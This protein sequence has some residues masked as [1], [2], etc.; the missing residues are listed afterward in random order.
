MLGNS[1]LS[2]DSGF[3]PRLLGFGE[4]APTYANGADSTAANHDEQTG[5]FKRNEHTE[6]ATFQRNSKESIK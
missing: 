4:A 2:A 6:I 5:R 1:S 3:E